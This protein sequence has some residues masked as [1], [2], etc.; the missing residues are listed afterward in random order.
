[1]HLTLPE[2]LLWSLGI[3]L[4]VLLCVLVSYRRLYRRL[5]FFSVYVMLLVI[6]AGTVWW[7]YRVWGY[8][9]RPAFYTY[10]IASLVVL[11]A[12]ALVVAELCRT[13][14]RDYRAI[15]PLVRKLLSAIALAVLSYA[16]IT[17]YRS[18]A[19]FPAFVLTAERGLEMS[20]AV[21]LT[22]LL[23]FG[24]R[25]KVALGPVRRNIATGLF[26]YSGFQ[27]LNNMFMQQWMSRYFHWWVSTRVIAFDLAL[28]VW[29]SPLRKPLGPP[30]SPPV[31][32]REQ[33]AVRLMREILLMMRELTDELKRIGR[34][35]RK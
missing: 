6:E 11:L 34:S 1:M 9:S 32:I 7:V 12:R 21:V 23:G 5:P 10:W 18:S 30:D 15:W 4:K 29:I 25:Y 13:S 20:F 31:V 2:T 14:L 16:A 8:R 19:H 33:V 22:A 27:V 28:L 26:V 35:I 24:V 17:A 3:A